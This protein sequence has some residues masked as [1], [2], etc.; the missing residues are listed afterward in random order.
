MNAA[1]E[2]LVISLCYGC[3]V[4]KMKLIY[5]LLQHYNNLSNKMNN[6]L[7]VVGNINHKYIVVE[8]ELWERNCLKKER[9]LRST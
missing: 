6:S 5:R 7:L 1:N 8:K 2:T 3:E 9:A 4:L